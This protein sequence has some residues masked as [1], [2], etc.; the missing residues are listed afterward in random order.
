MI[1]TY[2]IAS[3]SPTM[4]LH[5]KGSMLSKEQ[6]LLWPDLMAEY[7]I[8]LRANPGHT[9]HASMLD[10]C[11]QMR[12]EC[13]LIIFRLS[14]VEIYAA[15]ELFFLVSSITP[16]YLRLIS[17]I[18]IHSW[19]LGS[20]AYYQRPRE[21]L[22]AHG[23]PCHVREYLRYDIIMIARS[24]E[25][26]AQCHNLRHICLAVPHEV[27]TYLDRSVTHEGEFMLDIVDDLM[28]AGFAA[29][30]LELKFDDHDEDG[31]I[32]CPSCPS[33]WDRICWA[34]GRK[35]VSDVDDEADF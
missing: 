23:V 4:V 9:L 15:E 21:T 28:E 32:C 26:I 19:F 5:T 34:R 14:V 16:E 11:K 18:S 30:G 29:A 12:E 35:V 2:I 31:E 3:S 25:I 13:L 10:V 22:M 20:H 24:F 27:A 17:H 6:R 7:D 33:T 1:Y 8:A